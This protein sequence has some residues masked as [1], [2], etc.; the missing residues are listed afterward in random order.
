M[1]FEEVLGS[2]ISTSVKVGTTQY[3]LPLARRYLSQGPKNLS[4]FL[5]ALLNQDDR[6]LKQF[7][8]NKDVQIVVAYASFSL[9]D[10]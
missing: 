6:N 7:W 3:Q 1:V 4:I 9:L 5:R 8:L 10:L 2:T